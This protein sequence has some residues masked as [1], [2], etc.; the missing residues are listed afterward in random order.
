M[1]DG[2]IKAVSCRNTFVIHMSDGNWYNNSGSTIDPLPTVYDL[3]TNNL[4]SDIHDT[5]KG[6]TPITAN[7]YSILSF[8]DPSDCSGSAYKTCDYFLG[9]NSMQWAAMY[10]GFNTICNPA[11][12]P[13]P[14]TNPTFNS[15]TTP[16]CISTCTPS[17]T[18]G[19]YS[20]SGTNS[21]N[22]CC[23]EWNANKDTT[24]KGMPDNYYYAKSGAQLQQAL[25][26]I[27]ANITQQIGSSSAVATVAQQNTEGALIIRGAFEARA[28]DSDVADSTRYLW[29]G[30]LENFWPDKN[31]NYDFELFPTDTLCKSVLADSNAAGEANCRDA[32]MSPQWPS[33]ASRAVYTTKN[34][35]LTQ[36]TTGNITPTDLGSD[37][38]GYHHT[39]CNRKLGTW[40]G[41][42]RV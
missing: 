19:S 14:D 22:R 30:H 39:R 37:E 23:A 35:V 34:G 27:I 26:N 40:D 21:P 8:A 7:V 18:L 36:F 5:T 4:R 16:F 6:E 15:A 11:N 17:W 42:N 13:Y 25:T 24:R 29:F 28:P 31:G 10:G 2:T 12:L 3:H 20:C 1:L 9:T 38:H 33:P 41:S 32:A